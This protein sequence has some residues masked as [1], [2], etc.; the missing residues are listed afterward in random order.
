MI[1]LYAILTYKK[2]KNIDYKYQELKRRLLLIQTDT[3]RIIR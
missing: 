3:E 1:N 2:K